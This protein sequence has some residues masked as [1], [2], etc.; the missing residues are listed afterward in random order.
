MNVFGKE[1]DIDGMKLTFDWKYEARMPK[2]SVGFFK[3]TDALMR[4][5]EPLYLIYRYIEGLS[6]ESSVLARKYDVNLNLTLLRNG[7]IGDEYI[8]TNGHYHALVSGTQDTY[9]EIYQ[10]LRGSIMY[11]L[12][13]KNGRIFKAVEMKGGDV[14]VVPPNYMHAFANIGDA[15]ALMIDANAGESM[16]LPHDYKSVSDKKGFTYRLMR[17]GVFEKNDNYTEFPSVKREQ[18]TALFPGKQL[19]LAFMGNPGF[20]DKILKN[21]MK[22]LQ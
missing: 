7:F 19:D 16:R 13:H 18:P 20:F 22:F 17:G 14:I 1:F 4:E 5:T 11:M 9:P 15:P 10:V 12:Q 21:K 2:D 6:T 3:D 8:R